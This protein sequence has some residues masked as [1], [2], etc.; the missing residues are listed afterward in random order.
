MKMITNAQNSGDD[1]VLG[2]L[3]EI[4]PSLVSVGKLPLAAARLGFH[5]LPPEKMISFWAL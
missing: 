5:L 3:G 2:K 4:L 1:T